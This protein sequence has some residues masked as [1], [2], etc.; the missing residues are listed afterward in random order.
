M[1]PEKRKQNP[2]EVKWVGVG[3]GSREMERMIVA[4]DIFKKWIGLL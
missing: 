4:G 2:G 3:Q 1:A